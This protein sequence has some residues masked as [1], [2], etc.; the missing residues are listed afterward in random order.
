MSDS[1]LPTRQEVVLKALE[2]RGWVRL[3]DLQ[4][5][6]IDGIRV[7]GTGG[8]MSRE[9]LNAVLRDLRKEG[10]VDQRVPEA[11]H[12]EYRLLPEA[13]RRVRLDL[14]SAHLDLLFPRKGSRLEREL[15]KMRIALEWTPR[16]PI[17]KAIA[18]A[19]GGEI[20]D[21]VDYEKIRKRVQTGN[22]RRPSSKKKRK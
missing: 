19:A 2:G 22:R 20:R 15:E 16:T 17:E 18:M 1:P 3:R 10:F 4:G 21:G 6:V 13:Y 14:S 9:T 5:T 12:V 11:M 7:A 8:H